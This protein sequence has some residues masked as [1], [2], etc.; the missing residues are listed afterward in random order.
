MRNTDEKKE[1]QVLV[2]V[3]DTARSLSL[4]QFISVD[5]YTLERCHDAKGVLRL[6]SRKSFDVIV[7]DLALC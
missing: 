2:A 7:L 6:V 4:S 5:G 3:S 1:T